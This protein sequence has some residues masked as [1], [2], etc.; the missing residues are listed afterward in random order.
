[1]RAFGQRPGFDVLRCDVGDSADS[2]PETD[3][4]ATVVDPSFPSNVAA[5]ADADAVIVEAVSVNGVTENDTVSSVTDEETVALATSSDATSDEGKEQQQ[6]QDQ[7]DVLEMNSDNLDVVDDTLRQVP[8]K[9]VD[10]SQFSTPGYF[11]T[12]LNN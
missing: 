11:F 10:L 1:M 8:T 9:G 5:E 12:E 7:E 4:I 6:Q 2:K 3:S